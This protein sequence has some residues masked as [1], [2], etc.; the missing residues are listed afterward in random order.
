VFAPYQNYVGD[1]A[2]IY[3][4]YNLHA[5]YIFLQISPTSALAVYLFSTR[6]D[7]GVVSENL[8]GSGQLVFYMVL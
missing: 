2:S 5:L 7:C 4:D 3:V 1:A 8:G 6:E